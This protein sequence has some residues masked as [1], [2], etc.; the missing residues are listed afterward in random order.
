MKK[1]DIPIFSI[2]DLIDKGVRVD[3]EKNRFQTPMDTESYCYGVAGTVGIACLPIF[4]VPWEQAKNFAVRL[5]IAIQWTN[6][7]RDVGADAAMGRI[8]LPLDHLENFGCS[9]NDVLSQ[10]NTPEFERLMA[11]EGTVALSHYKRAD[12]LLPGEWNKQLLPARV[13]EKIYLK[14][15][16]KLSAQRYPVLTK[17]ISLNIFE[18]ARA[19][20][21][22][23]KKE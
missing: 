17:R 5:G 7:V 13:M 9:E 18:K 22:A 14:L 8:Y 6:I 23:L 21:G 4:G 11:Y 20:L 19:T 1:Y 15:L 16:E 12:E 3:L 10:K 2:L